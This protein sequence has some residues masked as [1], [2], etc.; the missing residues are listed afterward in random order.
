MASAHTG[1]HPQAVRELAKVSRGHPSVFSYSLQNECDPRSAAALLDNITSVDAQKPFV[2]NDDKLSAPA[3]YE[4]RTST[5]HAFAMLHYKSVDCPPGHSFRGGICAAQPML[6]GLGECA[7]CIDKGLESYAAVAV[8]ARRWDISYVAGWDLLNYWPNF[9]Q[10]ASYA[11]HAWKQQPCVS[12]DRTD[13]VD[14][15]NSSVVRWVQNSFSPHLVYDAEAYA[16]NPRWE[17]GWP[18]N[19]T[20]APAGSTVRR[21]LL[22]FNDVVDAPSAVLSLRWGGRW[23]PTDAQPAVSG[24]VDSVEVVAGFHAHVEIEIVLPPLPPSAPPAGARLWLR[25]ESVGADG[26][27]LFREDS[28]YLLVTRD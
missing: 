23:A 19:A 4:G 26:A 27:V 11:K 6:T 5:S 2:F 8:E 9:I 13:G 21:K 28:I 1:S 10:G 24:S 15:W 14:G 25:L 12:R 17:S 16:R 3:R 7:W 22:M 20:T 18:A